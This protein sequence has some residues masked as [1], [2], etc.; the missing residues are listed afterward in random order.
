MKQIR[1]PFPIALWWHFYA[2]P[3]PFSFPLY[4]FLHAYA[5]FSSAIVAIFA[6]S[7]WECLEVHSALS[8]SF[9]PFIF[10]CIS[11]RIS[12]IDFKGLWERNFK[13]ISYSETSLKRRND[14][15]QKGKFLFKKLYCFKKQSEPLKYCN[16][17][18]LCQG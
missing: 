14:N 4:E 7:Q 9:F 17:I 6:L 16:Q 8:F 15:W 5:K 1:L 11:I 2:L 3:F 12:H 10:F 18:S 13:N